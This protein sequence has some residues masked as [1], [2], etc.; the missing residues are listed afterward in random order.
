MI[1]GGA[2]QDT[3]L[4]DSE[5][6][7]KEGK[8]QIIT[9]HEDE[10]A[11]HKHKLS[12]PVTAHTE[13]QQITARTHDHAKH[14]LITPYLKKNPEQNNKSTLWEQL[15]TR[16][17]GWTKLGT[18]QKVNHGALRERPIRDFRR[19]ERYMNRL[20]HIWR[21]HRSSHPCTSPGPH[22]T[23]AK[24]GKWEGR[25]GGRTHRGCGQGCLPNQVGVR[26]GHAETQPRARLLHGRHRR[27]EVAG[28]RRGGGG[29]GGGRVGGLRRKEG[30]KE[31]KQR[32]KKE[33]EIEKK[34][35]NSDG[36]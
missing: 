3:Q 18:T 9:C 20:Y 26:D 22:S 2:T 19:G 6:N 1:F 5:A 13:P 32:K 28:E 29:R 36:G 17:E 16:T 33:R 11:T 31:E 14:T 21:S 35:S 15:H 27:L 8:S 7:L 4:P 10:C 12:W 25:G 23:H 24:S 30:R 34:G